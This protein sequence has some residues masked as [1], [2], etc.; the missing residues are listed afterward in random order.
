MK[1]QRRL[2]KNKVHLKIKK[3]TKKEVS[4]IFFSQYTLLSDFNGHKSLPLLD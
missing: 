3:I 2:P 1:G 4:L